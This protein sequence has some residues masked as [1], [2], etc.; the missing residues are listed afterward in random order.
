MQVVGGVISYFIADHLGSVVRVTDSAG[1]PTLTREYD[2]WGN[3]LQGSTTSGYTFTG[4]EWDPE[5]GFYY[6]RARYY[7]PTAGRF[8]SED[9]IG[10]T[11]TIDLYGYAL[12]NPLNFSDP[13]G[14]KPG[15]KK[16]ERDAAVM[17]AY[18]W[19][20]DQKFNLFYEFGG[21]VCQD[22]KNKCFFCT[23]P[24]TDPSDVRVHTGKAPCPAGSKDV[25]FY[26]THPWYDPQLNGLDP[27]GMAA[28]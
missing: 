5:T 22:D 27:L 28:V 26:H 17:D 6:Y 9:P 20:K 7:D 18:N 21:R 14:L 11:N 15:D 1:A 23:G 16:S 12:Q 25:G 3:P 13:L 24:V 19:L 10:P 8:I 4:R 2:P